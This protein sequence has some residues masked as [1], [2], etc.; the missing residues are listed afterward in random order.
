MSFLS[1][2]THYRVEFER[3]QETSIEGRYEVVVSLS[4]RS[5]IIE[6]NG[7]L[8]DTYFSNG[9]VCTFDPVALGVGE[10]IGNIWDS[11]RC[12]RLEEL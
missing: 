3:Q 2:Q 11:G 7:L 6:L 12:E 5:L 1:V 9:N 8:M 10:T 4:K